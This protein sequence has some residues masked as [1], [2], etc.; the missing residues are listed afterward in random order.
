MQD[1]HS[2]LQQFFTPHG[3]RLFEVHYNSR[4][5]SMLLTKG[6][7]L[8]QVIAAF[9]EGLITKAG[10]F[11]AYYQQYDANFTLLTIKQLVNLSFLSFSLTQT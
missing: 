9:N 7:T 1:I 4:Q 5:K 11:L 10:G 6:L 8:G 3:M 2:A